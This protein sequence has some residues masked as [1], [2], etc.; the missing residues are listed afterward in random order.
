[1]DKYNIYQTREEIPD[2][3]K[4]YLYTLLLSL[5]QYRVRQMRYVKPEMIGNRKYL[6]YGK[7]IAHLHEVAV[8]LWIIYQ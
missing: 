2:Q 8:Q 6:W 7:N 3:T 4:V 1:M 5:I